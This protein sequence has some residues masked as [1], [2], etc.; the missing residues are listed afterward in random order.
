MITVSENYEQC[1]VEGVNVQ[2]VAKVQPKRT[3]LQPCSCLLIA[4]L[5]VSKFVV[6][7]QALWIFNGCRRLELHP[8]NNLFNGDLYFL[9]VKGVL[10]GESRLM[11][12]EAA[13]RLS[14]RNILDL[15]DPRRDM[16]WT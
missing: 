10:Q 9:S 12:I 16:P 15:P 11:L 5:Q 13:K 6:Q 3:M 1:P 7:F 4:M 2:N 8:T 14:H